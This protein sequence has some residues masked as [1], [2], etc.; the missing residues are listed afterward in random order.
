VLQLRQIGDVLLTTPALA[1]LRRRFPEAQI[2]LVTESQCA[3]LLRGNPDIDRVIVLEKKKL[4]PFFR[5][6]AW[7]WRTAR[8]GYDLVI[9][10]QQLP[11]CRWISFFSGAPV[12]L[13]AAPRWYSRLIYN[14]VAPQGSGEYAAWNKVEALAPL[15]IANL[16]EAPRIFL[17]S[18]EREAAREL[19]SSLGLT[20]GQR[21]VTL[22]TTHRRRTR[23]WPAGHYAKLTAFLHEAEPALRFMPFWGPGEE[24]DIREL[25]AAMPEQVRAAVLMC[26][27][28]LS[29]REMAACLAEADLHIGN[30]SAPQ[31]IAVAT[32]T[33][34]CIIRGSTSG[35]WRYPSPDHVSVA[36]GLP[37]QPCQQD[38]CPH[39]DCLTQLKP[40]TVGKAALEMLARKKRKD[41]D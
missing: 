5:E 24:E 10:F 7:Y 23:R 18:E 31:H 25:C 8:G 6:F 21:L 36:A 12:R 35:E 3:Q 22:D 15:G 9:D 14:V 38:T 19:L 32:G 33:P 16:R 13:A 27:R 41:A 20:P 4:K 29:L 28:M 30:C 26:P 37:C 39:C 34:S 17:G 40:E 2:H 11:R 1:A